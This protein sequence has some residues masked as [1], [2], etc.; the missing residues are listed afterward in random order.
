MRVRSSWCGPAACRGAATFLQSTGWRAFRDAAT[1]AGRRRHSV[2]KWRSTATTRKRTRKTMRGKRRT[3][4]ERMC[5]DRPTQMAQ[6]HRNNARFRRSCLCHIH[7]HLCCPYGCFAGHRRHRRLRGH[8][9][10]RHQ[11]LP[12]T[13]GSRMWRTVAGRPTRRLMT[14]NASDAREPVPRYGPNPSHMLPHMAITAV[15]SVAGLSPPFC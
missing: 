14:A 13:R 7:R 1:A 3:V 4:A 2:E 12:T 9:Y 5:N 10:C 15:Q 11:S 6:L 8:L